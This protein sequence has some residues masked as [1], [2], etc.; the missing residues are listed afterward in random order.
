MADNGHT[1]THSDFLKKKIVIG[2]VTGAVNFNSSQTVFHHDDISS[3][4]RKRKHD[5][6]TWVKQD[7]LI[8]KHSD[9]NNSTDPENPI[10]ERRTRENFVKDRCKHCAYC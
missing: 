1:K 6:R 4:K 9:W 2:A 8:K 7:A 5:V 10:C 3:E